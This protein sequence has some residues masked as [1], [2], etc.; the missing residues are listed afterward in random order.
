M[1]LLLFIQ[2]IASPID[3]LYINNGFV[4][5]IDLLYISK[6]WVAFTMDDKYNV[7]DV[8][9]CMHQLYHTNSVM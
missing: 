2:K 1:T 9:L 3:R 7:H 8:N 5:T 4:N 6:E